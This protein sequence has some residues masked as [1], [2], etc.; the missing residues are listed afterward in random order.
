MEVKEI[1]SKIGK[2]EEKKESFFALVITAEKVRGAIWA[3]EKGETKVVAV[4]ET[5]SWTKEEDLLDAVDATL[6]SATEAFAPP[7]EEMKEPNK[8]IFGLPEG[9]VEAEKISSEKL[10]ILK[11]ISQKLDLKPVGFVVITEAIIHQLKVNEGVPPTV[12]LLALG[13]EEVWI[14]LV[15]LGKMTASTEVKRSQDLGADVAEGL[16]RLGKEK[17]FPARMLLY[18]SEEDLEKAK[19]ELLAYTWPSFF[20]HLPKVEV[21][22]A[23]FDIRAVALSGGREVAKAAG[24]KVLEPEI[25]KEEEKEGETPV[26]G[27]KPAGEEKE[28]VDFGFVRDKDIVKEKPPESEPLV[29]EESL[30]EEKEPVVSPHGEAP[31]TPSPGRRLPVIK[32]PQIDRT[33]LSLPKID[34]SKLTALFSLSRFEGKTSLIVGLVLVLLFVLGGLA[35]AAYWYLPRAQITLLVEPKTLEKEFEIKFDPALSQPEPANLALPASSVE[36]EVEGEKTVETTGTKLVG[37]PAKGEVTIF[38]RTESEKKFAAGTTISGPG[39]LEFTLDDDVIVASESAGPDYTK[40]P[41]KA[42]VSITAVK[43]GTE[44]N[45]AADSEFSVADYSTSDYIA[46]NGSALTG[47]TSREVSVVSEEDQ[48]NLVSVLT[49]EL[50]QKAIDELNPK[51]SPG[52]KLLEESLED[53]VVKKSFSQEVGDET[54]KLSLTLKIKFSAL[55]YQD[56]DFKNLIEDQIRETIPAGFEFKKEESQVS[57]KII[58]V[59]E[60]GSASFTATLKANLLPKIDLEE[61]RKN[62]TGK[63]PE[64]GEFYL[65]SLPNVVGFEAKINPHLPQRLETFP[66]LTKNIQIEVKLK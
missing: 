48:E 5:Q 20:L 57:F 61:I 39:S 43:I 44:G 29:A 6:S 66:R 50:Q 21:L 26:L 37:D 16:S 51:L 12:I 58:K 36:A 7:E 23:D 15:S 28:K 1:I 40:V 13:K 52:L 30:G 59:E 31:T 54:E 4:G 33:K 2:K 34:L 18:N 35:T 38:N 32:F 8:V 46:R 19:E 14:S 49:E 27:E 42:T 22:P 64:V 9:W 47:G 62:L 65:K 10:Q 11:D 24:I 53:T 45:L 56:E 25:K 63:Y 60:D 55:A 41:G 3:V 17:T